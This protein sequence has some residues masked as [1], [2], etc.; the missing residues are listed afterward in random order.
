MAK[1][2]KPLLIIF[3]KINKTHKSPQGDSKTRVVTGDYPKGNISEFHRPQV[4]MHLL[5]DSEDRVTGVP[6]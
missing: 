1:A 5:S 2:G 6:E 4:H 3:K